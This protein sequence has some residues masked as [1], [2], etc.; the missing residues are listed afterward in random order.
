[1]QGKWGRNYVPLEEY[2]SS[3]INISSSERI[4]ENWQKV[5][6]NLGTAL[7]LWYVNLVKYKGDVVTVKEPRKKT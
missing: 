3:G 2:N 6:Y 1:M 4:K 5:F 7:S